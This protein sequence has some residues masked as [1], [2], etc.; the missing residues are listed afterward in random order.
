[1]R[2]ESEA[3]ISVRPSFAATFPSLPRRWKG[4]SAL[5]HWKGLADTS[6][7]IARQPTATPPLAPKSAVISLNLDDLRFHSQGGLALSSRRE[8]TGWGGILP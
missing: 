8:T 4:E 1:M 3:S 5:Q 6:M 7:T 2:P